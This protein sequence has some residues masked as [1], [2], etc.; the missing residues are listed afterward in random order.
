[1]GDHP[2]APG[3]PSQGEEVDSDLPAVAQLG[4]RL[5]LLEQELLGGVWNG[6]RQVTE[7]H[8]RGRGEFDRLRRLRRV[9]V[10][11]SVVSREDEVLAAGQDFDP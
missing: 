10:N 2:E 9:E 3:H 7:A 8:A 5:D 11:P 6:T 4:A 1:L